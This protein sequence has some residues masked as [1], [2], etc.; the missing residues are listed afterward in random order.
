MPTQT[1]TV[2]ERRKKE[3]GLELGFDINIT[4]S[5]DLSTFLYSIRNVGAIYSFNKHAL[6]FHR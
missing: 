6:L 4:G 1:V 3:C 5:C 2:I